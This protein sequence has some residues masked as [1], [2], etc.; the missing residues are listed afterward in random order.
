MKLFISSFF[1]VVLVFSLTACDDDGPSGPDD[2]DVAAPTNLRASS[3][4]EALV[5]SWTPSASEAQDNFDGYKLHVENQSSFEYFYENAPPGNGHFIS[6]L[7]NGTRYIVS[8]RAVTKSGKESPTEVKIE[9]V[10]ATRRSVDAGGQTIRV[11]A[12]T[13]T[14]FNSAIDLFNPDGKAE[15]IPQA[16]E[17]F[18]TRGS[19]FV[20][21]PDAT[22]NFLVMRSPHTAG[23]QGLET[24]FSTV[25][26]DAD[27]LDEH[28]A[29]TPP[30]THTYT[31]SDM[32]I[33]AA[34]I[35]LGKVVYGR[36]KRG[37]VNYYFRLLVKRDA[38]GRMV[39]GSGLDRYLELVVSYQHISNIPFAKY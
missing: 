34:P 32:S 12:T 19:L 13:S 33:T 5:L 23:N 37:T 8:V 28:F 1:A 4:D 10:P 38:N 17:L 31:R 39:Q 2:P 36:L 21:A 27:D 25:T 15:V 11:Y 7:S 35:A 20:Y 14:T 3:A 16:S 22:S 29:T 24:Q 26:Y 18:R 6:G 9:W 30:A